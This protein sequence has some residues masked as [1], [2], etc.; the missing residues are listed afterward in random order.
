M[1]R[2]KPRVLCLDIEGGF[3]G[4]SRS[5]F[6]LIKHMDQSRYD[7]EVWC[8]RQGPIQS[9]YKE[10]GVP[11]RVLPQM[12]KVSSLPRLSR[13]VYVF[14]LAALD[15]LKAREFLKWS[16]REIHDRFDLV[17]FNHEALF[18]L[19]AWLRNRVRVPFVTHV[20][21][22][23]KHTPFSRFQYRTIARHSDRIIFI[24]ENERDNF[25]SLAGQGRGT[26]VYNIVEFPA[27]VPA[28]HPRIP[29]SDLFKVASLSNYSWHRATDRIV[30]LA[31]YLQKSGKEGILFVVAGDMRL[32]G[33]LPGDLGRVARKGGTLEHYVR[34]LGL[35]KFFLFLGHVQG[36]ESVLAGC[37]IVLRP[38]RG[39][40]PWGRD[41]IEAMA[42]GKPVIAMGNYSKFVESGL[43]GYLF[44]E[45]DPEKVA[46][47]IVYLSKHPDVVDRMAESNVRKARNLFDGFSNASKV[48][49][50]YDELLN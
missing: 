19:V 31:R 45:F 6:Y 42:Q 10:I 2:R 1:N 36:V 7:F 21:T 41:V 3:G 9:A 22:M 11:C 48:S 16:C 46:E 40:D 49:A 37:D 24:S 34:S 18:L 23:L 28:A 38:S 14:A 27:H 17:H 25:L 35:D 50:V 15:F 30:D 12:P 29:G 44:S 13:N 47:A 8:K 43:N 4:S 20:R 33:S 32:V 26:V 39:K 5:L